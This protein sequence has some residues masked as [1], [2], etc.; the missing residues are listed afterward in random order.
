VKRPAL[1]VVF[2][3][4]VAMILGAVSLTHSSQ[5]AIAAHLDGVVDCGTP[6]VVTLFAGQ[7]ID[8]GTVTVSN[9]DDFLYVT[10]LTANDWLLSET[11]LHVADSLA[12][13]PQTKKGNPKV[14]N[15]SYK[16]T[17]DPEVT[18]FTY[19]I[20]KAD[21][22]LDD[23]NSMVVA[24]HAV[25]VQYDDAGNQISNETGW[26]DGDRFVDRGSWATYF[27]HTWQ[28]CD[29][30]GG[31]D[32]S[33]T[34]TAFAF[35]EEI[36]TCF[37]DID[38][39][40][41]GNGDFNRWGWTNGALSQ[42][43]YEFDIY[44]GAGRCDTNKGTLVGTLT[45]D[46]DGSTATVTYNVTAPFGMVETHLYVGSDIL[47]SNS[48]DFTVAPGQYPTIHDELA[49]VSSDSYTIGGLSGDIYVVAHATV[50]GF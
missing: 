29:G 24:A 32:D 23:N 5:P 37:L 48:G 34:E 14:G 7:T 49:S 46:Y 2:P 41:D 12:G 20:A 3:I 8:S 33:G 28:A 16:T 38:V 31:G 25:V 35:G 6:T 13:I 18:E 22:S 10:F 26:G 43:S 4:L 30:S 11:H 40:E 50:D 42:G 39:D 15:F 45:V 9:D 17:H 44:A 1:A 21:L 36:S 27:M 19:V 47:A